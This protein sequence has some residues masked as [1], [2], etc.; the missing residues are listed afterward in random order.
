[1]SSG[2]Q[3]SRRRRAEERRR[4]EA[5]AAARRRWV[6]MAGLAV[7][8]IVV[9]GLGVGIGRAVAGQGP[10]PGPAVKTGSL[11]ALGALQAPGSQGPVGPEGIPIPQVPQLTSLGSAA[12]GSTVDGIQCD[13]T[14][15]VLFHIHAHLTIFVNGQQRQ[16]PYGIG[17][18]NVQAQQTPQG[19]FAASGSCFYWLHTHADDGIIHIESPVQKTFTLGDFFAI[20]GQ[21]LSTS[22]VGPAKGPVVALY[23]GKQYL[24]NPQ[25]I[26]LTNHA[27]IQL[28]VGKPLVSPVIVNSWAGL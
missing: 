13:S 28:E 4:A 9:I 19:P 24:G 8:V 21:P 18:P 15:Q 2:E 22:Q 6:R 27:N 10:A 1:M 23:N 5:R 12:T 7:V 25:D 26:P 16:I 17:I 11:S 20:W 3:P 14:E